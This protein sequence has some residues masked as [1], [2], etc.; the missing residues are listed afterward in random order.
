MDI[1]PSV[2]ETARETARKTKRGQPAALAAIEAVEAATKMP[3]DQG[4]EYEG[5]LFN[6]CLFSIESKALIHAFFGERTVAKIPGIGKDTPVYP[7]KSAAVIGAGT[8]GGGIAMNY[9]N[10]GIPVIVAEDPMSCV[11]IGTGQRVA[12]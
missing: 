5:K 10:T 6:E 7:I 3:F 4:C 11:A 1:D 9:A 2:Y 12:I 8:M